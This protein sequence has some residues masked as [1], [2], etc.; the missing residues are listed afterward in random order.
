MKK[1]LLVLGLMGV[2]FSSL[3]AQGITNKKGY[4]VLPEAGDYSISFDAVPIM[5]Y[6]FDKTRIFSNNAPSSATGLFNYQT[7]MTIVGKYMKD[8]NTAYRFKARLGFENTTE[9]TYV[10]K[11][12]STTN[13]QVLDTK[14]GSGNN[15]TLGAGIQKYRGKNRLRGYYG[16][17]ADLMFGHA[18]TYT[19][20]YGNALSTSNNTR[21]LT[22]NKSGSMFGFGARGFVGAEYYFAPKMSIGAE[23][24]WG[25]NFAKIGESS[26][27]Y[28]EWD[29]TTSAGKTFTLK[30]GAS[31]GFNLDVDNAGGAIMF[32]IYF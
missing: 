1:V 15:I 3:H 19:Y 31:G 2:G 22:E 9:N 18:P 24:G 10:N 28:E 30:N 13:E 20:T 26:L 23:F 5:N 16:A 8:E 7:P 4:A 17:E 14:K 27:T 12:G 11:I 6:A 25:L 32:S 21:R 29:P